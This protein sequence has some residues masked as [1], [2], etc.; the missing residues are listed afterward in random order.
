M[1]LL[2][3]AFAQNLKSYAR[4]AGITEIHL[5]QLR[6]SFARMV[7]EESGSIAETQQLATLS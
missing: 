3:H 5:H 6:H 1:Q 4:E 7:A 2:S